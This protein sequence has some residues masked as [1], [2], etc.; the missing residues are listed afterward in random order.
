[1]SKLRVGALVSGRGSNLQALLER[2]AEP[3]ARFAIVL[4]A[5][6]HADAFALQRARSFGVPAAVVERKEYPTRAQ[7][8]QAMVELLR[9]QEVDL[10]VLAGFDRVV[11]TELLVAFPGR[12]VNIHP[13][14]LPAFSG[15][16]H[17]QAEAL[18]YGVKVS[19]CTVHFVTETVDG[20]PIVLQTAVPVLEN[21]TAASLAERILA[22]E[23]QTLPR[24]VD[25]IARGLVRV[26]GRRVF[27]DAACES[28]EMNSE[29][30][31]R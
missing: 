9:Q 16:L 11:G 19:G 22:A 20:G 8:Q 12:I 10:V 18:A 30:E 3:D 1:M 21:D 14:L 2:S 4:V 5:S 29:V 23:H 17:A 24:A 15:G 31:Q 7:Q 25:L 6:N 28:K 13:S 26:E 27:I